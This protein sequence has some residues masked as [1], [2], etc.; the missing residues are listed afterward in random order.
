VTE[1]GFPPVARL[2]ALALLGAILL[3]AWQ[4]SGQQPHLMLQRGALGWQ[5]EEIYRSAGRCDA[6]LRRLHGKDGALAR[7]CVR[8]GDR[9]A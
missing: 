3:A 4:I 9:L 6:Q 5:I 2:L 8:V 1:V 7:Q